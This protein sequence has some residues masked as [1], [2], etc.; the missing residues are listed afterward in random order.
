MRRRIPLLLLCI[1]IAIPAFLCLD[2]WNSRNAPLFKRLERQWTDDVEQLEASGKLPPSWSD[3]SDIEVVGGTPE[4][5]EWLPRIQVPLKTKAK[6]G[7]KMEVLVVV[8]EEDGKR[9]ALVQYNITDAKT[10][11]NVWELGRT[12]ILSRPKSKDPLQ[13]LKDEFHL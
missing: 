9:G 5:R 6:G 2:F 1:A 13:A 3:V 4:T 10:G 12:F 7:H 8:W 11:N